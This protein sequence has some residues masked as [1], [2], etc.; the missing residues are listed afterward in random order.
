MDI[1]STVLRLS[2]VFLEL[3]QATAIHV[4]DCWMC[5][6]HSVADAPLAPIAPLQD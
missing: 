5:T 3:E 6:L 4:N 2:V 1:L